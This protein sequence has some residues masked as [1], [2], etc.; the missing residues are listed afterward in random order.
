MSEEKIEVGGFKGQE[1]LDALKGQKDMLEERLGSMDSEVK[2]IATRI[3]TAE[4]ALMPRKATVPGLEDEK[5]KFYFTKAI[6]AIVTGDWSDAGF[7]KEVFQATKDLSQG[8]GTAGGYVVPTQY[9]AEI[10]E[11]LRAKAVVV[12]AGA[13]MLSGLTGSPVEIPRQTGGATA[14]WT[15][16]NA[17]I[18]SSD[19]TLGQLSLTPKSCTAL[20]KISN[21]LVRMSTPSVEAMVRNDITKVLANAIDLAALRGSGVSNE[22]LGIANTS[23]IKT[24]AIGTN[25]GLFTPVHVSQMEGEL[26]DANALD[27]KLGFISHGKTKRILKQSRIPQFSGQTDGEYVFLPMSDAKLKDL[28]GYGWLTTSQIPTNLTKGSSTAVSE[29]YFANWVELLIGQWGGLEIMASKETSD[30]F[31]KNQTWVRIIQEV[32]IGVRHAESFCLVNDAATTNP[33]A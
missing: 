3:E 6:S 15:A 30:A 13:T 11:L 24:V 10:I 17:A 22:P 18:T 5:D 9:I 28:L 1:I 7:E 25:G 31:A 16:E 19:Q 23:G 26:E 12:Q 8:T 2:A 14:Y 4:K 29:V 32:D 21:R 20:T 33:V 27:G